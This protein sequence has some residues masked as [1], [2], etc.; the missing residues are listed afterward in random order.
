MLPKPMKARSA[1]VV[2]PE[3]GCESYMSVFVKLN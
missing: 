2:P 1:V 3:K